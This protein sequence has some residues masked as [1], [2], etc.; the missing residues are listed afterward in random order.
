MNA[1]SYISAFVRKEHGEQGWRKEL[2][3]K[4]SDNAITRFNSEKQRGKDR[5]RERQSSENRLF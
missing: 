4:V 3:T 2:H 5:E 1:R